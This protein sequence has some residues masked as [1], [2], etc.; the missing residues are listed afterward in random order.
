MVAE[1]KY[2]RKDNRN[3]LNRR[4]N[5]VKDETKVCFAALQEMFKN[6]EKEADVPFAETKQTVKDSETNV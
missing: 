1:N 2:E 6:M 4:V 5:N 3:R